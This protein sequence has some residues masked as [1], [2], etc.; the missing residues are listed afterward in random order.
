[1]YF[2]LVTAILMPEHHHFGWCFLVLVLAS[3][4]LLARNLKFLQRSG[5]Y[6]VRLTV[7]I[8]LSAVIDRKPTKVIGK[9]KAKGKG[10]EN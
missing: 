9:P 6:V 4:R 3:P 2:F 5:S 10:S 7:V 1:M 8:G